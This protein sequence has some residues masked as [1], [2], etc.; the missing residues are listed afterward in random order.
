MT[1]PPSV[2]FH[3]TTQAG[4]LG[5]LEGDAIWATKIHYLNDSS[6]YQLA[7]DLAEGFLNSLL[8]GERSKIK[9]RKVHCLLE[10]LQTIASMNVCVCSFSAERDLLSQWRAYSGK[11]GGYSIGFDTALI[12]K[13]GQAQGFI[14]AQCIYDSKEQER[15]VQE[16]VIGSLEIDFNTRPSRVDPK[17]S[18]TIVALR[19]GG[20]FA[21]N[22]ARLAPIIKSQAFYEEQEWRLISTA[23]VS[24]YDMSFR[25]GQSML[26]PYISVRLGEDKGAYLKS[27]TVGPTPHTELAK[28]A[29]ES[30]LW[31]W[32]IASP[33]EVRSSKAPYRGW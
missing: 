30:L 29:T 27:V 15:L 9:K 24:V 21:M 10:N 20:N 26:T 28:L 17:R 14:L 11:P 13:Q 2:L 8:V 5:V 33:V 22:I 1:N 4:L 25:P 32:R 18:R 12:Q 7:L 19:T 6:E 16:L 31:R 23:G 3:Y